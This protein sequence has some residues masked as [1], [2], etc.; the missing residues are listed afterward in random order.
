MQSDYDNRPVYCF[1][2]AS[3]IFE[4][5]LAFIEIDDCLLMLLRTDIVHSL[6]V[7]FVNVIYE[8]L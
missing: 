1:T 6:I 3:S 7:K 4:D 8:F 5:F 2:A